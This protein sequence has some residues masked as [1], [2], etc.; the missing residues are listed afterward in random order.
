M[1]PLLRVY[2]SASA[3]LF[4]L[5]LPFLQNR[6][7]AGWGE[8]CGVYSDDKRRLFTG[9]GD[10]ET[11]ENAK[12]LWIHSV[13]VGEVQAASPLAETALS[14]ERCG[15]VIISTV[16]ETGAGSVNNIFGDRIVHIYAPWDSPGIVRRACDAV[17]P[18]AYVAVETE[19]WPN[20]LH[21]LKTRRVP[22]F[23]ANGRISDRTW[24]RVEGSRTVREFL[25][26]TYSLF[27]RIFART[28]EDAERMYNMGIEEE[29][30]HVAGDCKVDAVMARRAAAADR[31][32]RLREKL[33]LSGAEPCFV[34]GS[35]H[36]GE[37]EIVLEAF[38]R[39]RS[40]ADAPEGARLIIAPRHPERAAAVLELAKNHG[41]AS[42]FSELDGT[43][44]KNQKDA[45]DIVVVD[46][47]GVLFELYG[48]A[49]SVFIGGSIVP[50]GGQNILE[51]ASWGVPI[52]H[53]PHMDDFA[54]P[55][56]RLDEDSCAYEVHSASEMES[57]W[58]RAARGELPDAVEGGAAYFADNSGA[59]LSIWN[60][61]E[62]Y[63]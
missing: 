41:S 36:S 32:P 39:L 60:H 7:S 63:L 47:I 31:V 23:L 33:L 22:T 11:A 43:G 17:R 3:L 27:D 21:E 15:R 24:K 12:R 53:G 6:H 8:R 9:G 29:L 57:L 35:T 51:P 2:R 20:I 18:S 44:Q 48:L 58:R 45:P 5:A 55:T 25:K 46:V 34:A 28:T 13:S 30:I 10:G 50:S 16:T 62:R 54:E 4:P 52:L 38:S 61:I 56:A 59:S 26:E 37:D 42:L 19:I 40:G 14:S 1:P 49:L